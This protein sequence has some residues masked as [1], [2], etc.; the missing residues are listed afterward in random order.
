MRYQRVHEILKSD[1]ALT[2]RLSKRMAAV[3]APDQ[4]HKDFPVEVVHVTDQIHAQNL[5]AY[6]LPKPEVIRWAT[7]L[8]I[9]HPVPIP[10]YEPPAASAEAKP[11]PEA[12]AKTTRKKAASA[13]PPQLPPPKKAAP[14]PK[15]KSPKARATA[16]RPAAVEQKPTGDQGGESTSPPLF[17]RKSIPYIPGVAILSNLFG[18]AQL[19]QPHIVNDPTM[20][21]VYQ[22][23]LDLTDE[24]HRATVLP[25]DAETKPATTG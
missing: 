18:A 16:D 5:D 1:R 25:A 21:G 11:K 22:K 24:V 20:K 4:T 15:G 2:M 8:L 10:V 3:C 6:T 7:R 17:V 12:K 9:T 23:L 13:P 19:M 14:K